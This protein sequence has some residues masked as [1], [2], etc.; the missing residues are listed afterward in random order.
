MRRRM[1]VA[2]VAQAADGAFEVAERVA[3]DAS[4]RGV[5]LRLL[6]GQAV[7]LLCPSFPARA[8]QG[9]DMDF[10]SVS[11]AKGAVMEFLAGHGFL[12]DRRFNTIH[13]DRQMYFTTPDGQ[14][15]VDVIMDRL[16]MCHV[17]EFKARIDRMPYTLDV[18]DLLLTKLQ[19][20][21][22]NEKDVQ[23]I[24]YLLAA[25]E[26]REGDVP[27]TIG[28]GRIGDVVGSD[29]GWWRTVTR[30]LDRVI[31]LA[32]GDLRRLVPGESPHDP[33][34][35]GRRLRE[36][37]DATPKTLKWKIRAKVGEHAQWYE[38]PEETGH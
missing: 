18:T 23:D 30:N 7:R 33:V 28:L 3:R 25:F 9:Q 19:V 29:W 36:H 26:V 21:E 12:G 15:S 2:L 20:V 27:G 34:E 1:G 4:D 22:Q 35:Q 10:A 11:S 31:E 6:G 14:T 16:R 5:P 32:R 17:L 24:V 37:A 8:R 13:G 38:L